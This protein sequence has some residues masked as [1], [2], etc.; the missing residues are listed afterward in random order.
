M[1]TFHVSRAYGATAGAVVMF[2]VSSLS[3]AQAAVSLDEAVKIIDSFRADTKPG[4]AAGQVPASFVPPPRTIADITAIL[5]KQKP[6]P[7]MRAKAMAAAAA[8]PPANAPASELAQ[9]FQRR[10]YANGNIGRLK[11]GLADAA[12]ALE[13]AQA[14]HFDPRVVDT[15]RR[16]LSSF[17]RSNGDLNGA[18][19]SYEARLAF[20]ATSPSPPMGAYV[21][22]YG[23]L[24]GAALSRG[25]IDKA[26][27]Y[28]DLMEKTL[29]KALSGRVSEV[30]RANLM[31]NAIP[32]RV[33]Y[34]MEMG[35]Y[36]DAE[37]QTRLLLMYID[38]LDGNEQL[39]NISVGSAKDQ[40]DS[41]Y[42]QLS[43][44]LRIQ[45]RLVE[46]EAEGRRAL[47]SR[48]ERRGRYSMHAAGSMI[49]LTRTLLEQGRYAEAEQMA[50]AARD[51]YEKLG[52]GPGS[53][54]LAGARMWLA[55]AQSILGKR[56]AARAT[57]EA[58]ARDV[59]DD[60]GL[61]R[62]HLE[63][64]IDYAQILLRSGRER[65]GV[66][67]L[68]NVVA[69]NAGTLGD[70]SYLTAQAR[71]W[72][73]TALLRTGQRE[74]ASSEFAT[75]IPILIAASREA[76]DA[77]EGDSSVAS[78]DRQRQLIIEAYLGLLADTR[79]SA[80]ANETFR[81]ADAIR[82]RSVQRALTASAARAAV[83][84]SALSNLVRHEQDAQKQAAAMQ[85]LLT[86]ILTRPIDEQDAGAV[87][88]LRA[89]IDRL[90][91]ARARVREEIEG[92]FPEYVEL[93]D[94]RP[95][96][97]E[98]AQK[99]L[100][101]GEALIATYVGTDRLF[102]WAI[103]QQGAA[104]Y[105]SSQVAETSVEKMVAD[106]RRSLDPNAATIEEVP[107]FDVALAH[108]LYELLLAPV[109]AGWKT[110]QSLLVVPH[111]AIGG[112]PMA[113]LV[114]EAV[115]QPAKA[116]LP[117]SEYKS[118]PFLARKVAVTQLPSVASLA[119]L[120]ALPP[121]KPNRE[122]L[123]AF[124]DPW[125]SPA[126]AQEAKS[127]QAATAL[128][129]RGGKLQ[130]RGIPLVRRSAP[131]TKVD[132]AELALLP[133]LPDTADEV[134]S[135]A[136]ALRA[137]LAKDVFVGEAA[138]EKTVKTMNLAGRRVIVFA[139]H[140]LVPGDLNG[141][142]QPALALSAPAVAKIDGDGLLTMEEI[143]ALKLD[144]DWVVLSACNT[145]SGAGAGAEAVSGLGRAFFYAGT[146]ALLVS[147][148]P[149]ETVS[150]RTLTTD[151]FRRQADQPALTRAEALRMAE[152]ALI[153]GPGAI[154]PDTK[155]PLFSYAHPIFWAP[156]TVVGDGGASVQ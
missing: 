50:D 81:L 2:C 26:R 75:A 111:K 17:Q 3:V 96:T 6:D 77:D 43:A 19:A 20:F 32:A 120:R 131:N 130:T 84:D 104:A 142:S 95:A 147:N 82:G 88:K 73:A 35:R 27:E 42:E 93:I 114:T 67:I 155:Q 156:F 61:K 11:E 132:S 140:G 152:V 62:R 139:T 83:T 125:F 101:P 113:L 148:W 51:V 21:G 36:A 66:A 134:K 102:V 127:Q 63:L 119:T 143:L 112:L 103:P 117:F 23:N 68:E 30:G 145:A 39:V 78:R 9:F 153:D 29:D 45:G 100:R 18:V 12:Q 41:A 38:K 110:A 137:D 69:Q 109:S 151:L 49:T 129:T 65:E 141:L 60:P 94:P 71:G 44:A 55:Q 37:A 115:P 99:S 79:G 118:T 98:Q 154:D 40:R 136:V 10:S 128:Q 126:Q 76:D 59:A 85:G 124:G 108:K 34:H 57:Y 15:Y 4:D 56:D 7:E 116:T 47:L 70:K 46:A 90:R 64:N 92:R 146:R 58:L 150:A 149:V 106:L 25:Q 16:D 122:I 91:T 74:R 8:Q 138:N 53:R 1:A 133:R 48:L 72:L 5:D 123:A 105:A 52:H 107:A 24:A 14:A 86:N 135:I 28:V 121:P 80:A 33:G 89:Q 31:A 144:A 54:Q 13:Q 97:L 87:Q 22:T